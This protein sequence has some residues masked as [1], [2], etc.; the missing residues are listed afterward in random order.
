[1]KNNKQQTTA[2]KQETTANTR[3]E[4]V[5]LNQND[6]IISNKCFELNKNYDYLKYRLKSNINATPYINNLNVEI[7]TI[8]NFLSND[9]CDRIV[10]IAPDSFQKSG[11]VGKSND[12]KYR[13]SHTLFYDKKCNKD[14]VN[15]LEYIENKICTK[16]KIPREFSERLQ[17]T[18]YNSG[19]SYKFHMDGFNTNDSPLHPDRGSQ[20]SY[21]F[22]IYLSDVEEGGATF[23]P[24]LNKR[25]N[26]EKGKAVIWNNL[27]DD[28]TRNHSTTHT[29]ECVVK[30]QKYIITKWFRIGIVKI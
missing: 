23:F 13:T 25:F 18:Y 30:G 20:R 6:Y 26:P 5:R 3:E 11:T 9:E 19:E 28:G 27:N 1:M 15:F 12:D 16:I 17:I 21:T 10:K 24:E 29:G 8:D 14:D 2:N 22:M 4:Y 7:Y